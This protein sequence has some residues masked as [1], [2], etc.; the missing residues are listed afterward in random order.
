[1]N[2]NLINSDLNNTGTHRGAG[3]GNDTPDLA[4]NQYEP[5]DTS[6][7]SQTMWCGQ[8]DPTPMDTA[9]EQLEELLATRSG[10]A[11]VTALIAWGDSHAKQTA[12]DCSIATAMRLLDLFDR[13]HN[14]RLLSYAIR[15]VFGFS[16]VTEYTD[17]QKAEELGITPQ[18]VSKQVQRMSKLF[19]VRSNYMYAERK[20]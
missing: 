9:A 11:L 14:T 2:R 10:A 16:D 19:G 15:R 4:T 7:V 12:T 17:R 8:R 13:S 20:N 3:R 5:L 1:M 18:A 6:R